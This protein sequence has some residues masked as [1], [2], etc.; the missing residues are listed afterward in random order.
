MSAGTKHLSSKQERNDLPASTLTGSAGSSFFRILPVQALVCSLLLM[1]HSP[2]SAGIREEA[3]LN[4][5][6]HPPVPADTL[7]YPARTRQG[8][9]EVFSPDGWHPFFIK[10]VNLGAA[11]PGRFPSDFPDEAVYADWIEEIA[12]MGANVVRVYT[13][14]PPEF[15]RSLLRHNEANRDRPLRIIH[16]VWTGLPPESDYLDPEWE[17]AFFEEMKRVV[18]VVHGRANLPYRPGEASGLYTADVSAWTLA[19]I[20]GREWEPFSV[21]AF[22]ENSGDEEGWEGEY[23]KVHGGNAMDAWLGKA[24]EHIIA[25]ETGLYRSQRPVA[26]TNW[27]TLDPLH[28]PTE[29][30]TVEEVEIRRSMGQQVTYDPEKEHNDDDAIG[31]DATLVTATDQYPAGYFASYHIYPYYPDFMNLDAGYGLASSSLGPSRF[32][33][34]MQDLKEHHGDMPVVVAEYGVPASLGI[35]HLQ[36]QGWHH[37]GHDEMTMAELNRLQT[38]E[39]AEAGMAGGIVFAWIDEWFKRNWL[40]L[41]YE[42]PSERNRFWHNRMDPEQNYGIIATESKFAVPGEDLRNRLTAWRA[43]DPI[44]SHGD[45]KE[46]RAAADAAFLWILMETGPDTEHEEILI[47]FDIV[48]PGTGDFGWPDGRGSPLPIGVEFVL[49]VTGDGVELLVD[50]PQNQY[51][52]LFQD[53]Q[54]EETRT[55]A[56]MVGR[57]PPGTFQG[58][59]Y[60]APNTTFLSERNDDG[61]YEPLRVVTNRLRFG[62]DGTEYPAVGYNR[63]ILREGA[64]PDGCWERIPEEGILEIR[65]PWILL[66]I[67]DPSSHQ[68]L[69]GEMGTVKVQDI[70][71]VV[72]MQHGGEWID[73]PEIGRGETAARFMWNGWEEPDWSSRKR[74]VYS[75]LQEV[76]SHLDP[77]RD[78]TRFRAD[79]AWNRGDLEEATPLYVAYLESEPDDI[80]ALHRLALARAWSGK[81][82]ESLELFDR[83]LE[84]EPADLEIQINHSRVL[85]WA[86]KYDQAI[87]KL[88]KILEEQPDERQ[89]LEALGLFQSWARR[90]D[91]SLATFDRILAV[92]PDDPAILHSKAR[93]LGWA[94]RF[95]ASAAIYDTLLTMD[96]NDLEARLGLAQVLARAGHLDSA[97]VAYRQLLEDD[98]ENLQA[99]Q[100]EARVLA[101]RGSLMES[102]TVWRKVLALDNSDIT[103]ITGLSQNLRWQGRSAAAMEVLTLASE[104]ARNEEVWREE[105]RWVRIALGP[106]IRPSYI[107]ENDSDGNRIDTFLLGAAWHPYPRLEIGLNTY[108][109][110]AEQPALLRQS[111]SVS[112]SAGY[113]TVPGW[114]LSFGLG[115][116]TTDAVDAASTLLMQASITSP[117]R[118]RVGASLGFARQPFDYTAMLID[119]GVQLKQL[120]T[121]IWWRPSSSWRV[122]GFFS[123]GHF[124]GTEKNRRTLL[125]GVVTHDIFGG[126]SLGP[127]IRMFQFQKNLT[128]G[129]FDPDFYGIGEFILTWRGSHRKWSIQVDTAPAVQKVT[130]RGSLTGSFRCSARLAFQAGPG[131]EFSASAGYS[132]NGIQ[133]LSAGDS[134][135]R[136]RSF[137]L[138]GIW[139]F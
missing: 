121:R 114:N 6:D 29:S 80:R 74:P 71:I 86:G 97:Y 5:V 19:F 48:D 36:T 95:D 106:R 50:P 133:R 37:G 10:G 96:P 52:V 132:S 129:Y 60:Q 51:R 104:E 22:Q 17:G 34:Y 120:S 61:Y 55:E 25:Y 56:A 43:I 45:G 62:R 117:G 18:D 1:G 49:T 123:V 3:V 90:F 32:F 108:L 138:A 63:G 24:C 16:G 122:N 100:G 81:H 12:G 135:Y 23:L 73:M 39:I 89:V 139:V 21:V 84:L 136:Y 93:V 126:W 113:Q 27:P 94:T 47:G 28:H 31:L 102:E 35:A 75:L 41:D 67:T 92:T 30:T 78:D 20:I 64:P 13:I 7:F 4:Q 70:G 58:R 68:V 59:V 38:L 125:T 128:D 111:R 54:T 87:A 15:Y 79:S 26:Y 77:Y 130:Q 11:L 134:D 72:A 118:S 98:P 107:S 85:A 2:A 76:F 101:W 109:R 69:Y 14:H 33:G 57:Q 103:T 53:V 83:L 105:Y 124:L 40:Y 65:I 9:F 137:S 42:L 46:V 131:R 88:E 115:I 119:N 110:W 99:L 66:N 8:R 91:D 82:E 112:L 116:N 127:G 44:Y